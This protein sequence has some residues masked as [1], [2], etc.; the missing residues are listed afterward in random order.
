MTA[1]RLIDAVSWLTTPLL[2]DDYLGLLNPLWSA[3]E[4]RGRVESVRPETRD[5][6]SLVI[7][8]GRGRV[9][10][11]A[12][13]Y[14]RVGVDTGGV[15]H[16]RSYSVSS[17]PARADGSTRRQPATRRRRAVGR[18]DAE[19]LPHGDLLPLCGTTD[20]RPGP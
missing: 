3:R 14:V 6:A 13:Q 2:P 10:H 7:R 8:P 19:R 15:L 16:W 4:L 5:A 9:P 12:G 17:A 20:I 11:R 1:G 18:A